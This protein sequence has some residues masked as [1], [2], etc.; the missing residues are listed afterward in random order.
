MKPRNRVIA[1][2]PVPM[3]PLDTPEGSDEEALPEKVEKETPAQPP[4]VVAPQSPAVPKTEEDIQN[5]IIEK[6]I[7]AELP[8]ELVH[9]L[10]RLSYYLASVGLEFDEACRIVRCAPETMRAHIA[11]YP[12]IQELIDLKELRY[13]TDL[14]KTISHKAIEGKDDKLAQWLLERRFP[15]E[16]NPKKGSGAGGGESDVD[17][18][19]IAMEFIQKTGDST[20]LIKETSGR[21]FVLKKNSGEQIVTAVQQVRDILA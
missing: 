21:A 18:L 16:F 20:P 10:Q 13:K 14:I 15:G 17:L 2:K 8:A 4:A 9:T 19:G 6:K 7:L 11:Q 3:E 12:I 1:S 5:D